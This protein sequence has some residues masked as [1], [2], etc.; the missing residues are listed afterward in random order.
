MNLKELRAV[1]IITGDVF[2]GKTKLLKDINKEIDNSKFID[3]ELLDAEA[4]NEVADAK[5]IEHWFR[6]VFGVAFKKDEKASYAV[7]I[8]T[9]GLNCKEGDAFIIRNPEINLHGKSVSR[10]AKFFTFLASQKGIKVIL[11]TNAVDILNSICCEVFAKNI[12]SNSV[13][14][15]HKKDES[16]IEK[17]YVNNNGKFANEDGS[18][19]KYP[20][21]FFDANTAELWELL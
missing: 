11:E 16:S 14:F 10:I 7:K 20:I 2:S 17:I 9:A 13:I 5:W 6:F 21:G 15:L 3:F 4:K 8:L 1:N 12:D 19:R 18:L